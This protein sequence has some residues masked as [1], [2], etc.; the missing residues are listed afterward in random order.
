[1]MLHSV[2]K[3]LF[4]SLF[5]LFFPLRCQTCGKSL[6]SGESVL[7]SDCNFKMPRTGYACQPDNRMELL[8]QEVPHFKHAAAYF[9]YNKQS[10]HSRLVL[11]IKY[12]YRKDVAVAVGSMMATEISLTSNFFQ[13]IDLIVPVPLHPQRFKERG[14][15]QSERLA[16]GISQM[17]GIAVESTSLVRIHNGTAQKELSRSARTA[18]RNDVFRLTATEPFCHKHILLVDDVFTTGNTIKACIDTFEE[19]EDVS[20]SVLTL[21]IADY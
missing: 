21:S 4:V 9:Y 16:A 2:V 20:F 12:R 18:I 5:R 7:C 14:Y 13:G 15:N 6:Q 10:L 19:V 8:L 11:H 1:M 3:E 17:T